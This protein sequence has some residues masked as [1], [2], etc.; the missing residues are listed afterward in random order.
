[1]NSDSNK[2]KDNVDDLLDS[3]G[4]EKSNPSNNDSD[5]DMIDFEPND[6]VV[7]LG[8]T[9]SGKSTL[10]N[11]LINE[12]VSKVDDSLESVTKNIIYHK[13]SDLMFCDTPGFLDS[14]DEVA[15][16]K[17]LVNFFIKLQTAKAFIWVINAQEIRADKSISDNYD[18]ISEIINGFQ[19]TNLILY[20]AREIDQKKKNKWINYFDKKIKF[21]KIFWNEQTLD[22]IDYA[23]LLTQFTP[24]VTKQLK[25]F[26]TNNTSTKLSDVLKQTNLGRIMTKKYNLQN[27]RLNEFIEANRVLGVNNEGL[28]KQRLELDNKFILMNDTMRQTNIGLNIL[29][30]DNTKLLEQLESIKLTSLKDKEK[31]DQELLLGKSENSDLIKKLIKQN[32]LIF[33]YESDKILFKME[34]LRLN[35]GRLVPTL[36][37]ILHD[38]SIR[39]YNH[40]LS[41]GSKSDKTCSLCLGSR[42]V[43]NLTNGMDELCGNCGDDS[44][45]GHKDF[46]VPDEK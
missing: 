3:I 10:F 18:L 16:Y 28:I 4:D 29:K 11:K 34:Q 44:E 43:A 12:N 32:D 41:T 33:Q 6:C 2:D 31:Y 24:I 9:G 17:K 22:L 46:V 21:N 15:I 19:I 1:M 8:K 27:N 5:E 23:R 40:G 42:V 14:C 39:R 25:Q 30:V 45:F 26:L 7:I 35:E 20:F 36:Q 13:K 37:E 38:K